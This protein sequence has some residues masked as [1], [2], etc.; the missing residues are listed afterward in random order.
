MAGD[1]PQALPTGILVPKRIAAILQE[2]G[3]NIH[4][5]HLNG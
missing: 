5:M 1:L 3:R 4:Q 2:E